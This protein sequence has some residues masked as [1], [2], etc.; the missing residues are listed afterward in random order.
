MCTL[1]I[2]NHSNSS[3]ILAHCACYLQAQALRPARA[4]WYGGV[5]KMSVGLQKM[6]SRSTPGVQWVCSPKV[7][8]KRQNFNVECTMSVQKMCVPKSAYILGGIYSYRVYLSGPR[9]LAIAEN[10]RVLASPER[11]FEGYASL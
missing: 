2:E 9:E 10:P 3:R 8:K 11:V 4:P 7:A 1:L 5:A 6:Y